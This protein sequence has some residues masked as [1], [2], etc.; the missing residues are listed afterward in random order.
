MT[1]SPA[2][3]PVMDELPVATIGHNSGLI[4]STL[5]DLDAIEKEIPAYLEQEYPDLVK[6]L[7]EI[8]AGSVGLP[9][10]ID[11]EA[12]A[13]KFSDIR[14]MIKKWMT[15]AKA[16][17]TAE[18]KPWASVGDVFYAW[19]TRPIDE[20][21]ALD[22]KVVAPVLEDWQS[23]EAARKRREA[24]EEARAKREE[25]ER[26]ERAARE[27]ENRRLE[28]E[29]A[30][31]EAKA[32]AEQAERDRQA[33]I[34]RQ[35]AAKAERERQEKAAKEA[36]AR[37]AEAKRQAEAAAKQKAIDEAAAAAAR[38][39]QADAEAIVAAEK[40]KADEARA[41]AAKAQ[42]EE[43]AAKAAA[44]RQRDEIKAADRAAI[45]ARVDQRMAKRDER[46]SMDA[47]LAAEKK[48]DKHEDTANAKAADLTRVRGEFGSVSSL[49]EFKN[50]RN[51]DRGAIDWSQVGPF[52]SDEHLEAA[53]R[54]MLRAGVYSIRGVEVFDDT[55]TATR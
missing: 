22:A 12:D 2:P 51:V 15:A 52:V 31:R 29:R 19:F 42:E 13:A 8:R 14:G 4:Q 24:E 1:D 54:A 5:R 44:A 48:A 9:T 30:E 39:A 16:A 32:R 50:F 25:Q 49:K 43:R 6:R 47:A 55:S 38:K 10:R 34:A 3:I 18:K 35:E 26:Q 40:K 46:E 36:E 45:D 53:I 21:T 27:A 41:A 20:L 7:A 11:S 28:A 33:E 23:R 37:A 17:R